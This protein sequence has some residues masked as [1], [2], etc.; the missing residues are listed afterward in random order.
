M[1]LKMMFSLNQ[2]RFGI[3]KVQEKEKTHN[4]T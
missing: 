1:K 3:Q 2:D 4:G